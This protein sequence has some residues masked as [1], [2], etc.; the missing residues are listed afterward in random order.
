MCKRHDDDIGIENAQFVE[1]D[2]PD[3][4]QIF[5][6]PTCQR[7]VQYVL[8][9]AASMVMPSWMKDT[10]GNEGRTKL[11]SKSVRAFFQL[12]GDQIMQILS[13]NAMVVTADVN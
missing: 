4:G 10:V 3:G 5:Q 2:E 7:C 6:L 8:A 11:A 13:V 12:F 1:A 9:L